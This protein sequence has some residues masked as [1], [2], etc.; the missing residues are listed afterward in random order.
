VQG[1]EVGVSRQG[2]L[3]ESALGTQR[4]YPDLDDIMPSTR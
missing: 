3:L 4:R 2:R 1:A